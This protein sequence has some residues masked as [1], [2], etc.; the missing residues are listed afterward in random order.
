MKAKVNLTIDADLTREARAL[1]L[2]LSSLAEEAIGEA[3]SRERNRR[4]VAENRAA[5]ETY[6]QEIETQGLAL[7]HLRTF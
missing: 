1:S 7:A 4:W 6:A 3:V 2:N 5:L